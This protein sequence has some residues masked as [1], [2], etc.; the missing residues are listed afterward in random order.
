VRVAVFGASGPVG[1][2]VVEALLADPQHRVDAVI[3]LD[4]RLPLEPQPGVDWRE[5]GGTLAP[6]GGLAG[7]LK[8]VDAVVNV[9]GRGSGR[10]AADDIDLARQVLDAVAEAGVRHLVQG[11]TFAV[12]SPVEQGHDPVDESWPVEGVADVRFARRAVALERLLDTFSAEHA[13]VRVVRL[14]SGLVLGPRALSEFLRRLGPL[15]PYYRAPGRLPVLP[16]VEG[17]LPVVHHDDLAIAFRA[18]VTASVAGAFNIAMDAPLD[19]RGAAGALGARPV[20]VPEEL[21]RIGTELASAVLAAT[22]RDTDR[23]P[24][25]WLLMARGAPRLATWRARQELGWLPVHP[26]DESLRTTLSGRP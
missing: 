11:S 12:Y 26:L 8:G 16:G 18:A 23:A 10:D 21:V 1:A 7:Q 9:L 4:H 5:L 22:R 13:A 17:A 15:A 2:S 3:G 24:G 6:G 19:L 25:A 20:A 14:R